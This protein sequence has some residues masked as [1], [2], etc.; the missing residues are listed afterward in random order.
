LPQDTS[1]NGDEICYITNYGELS[2]TTKPEI[3][4]LPT[5][6]K[7]AEAIQA[8]WTYLT[9]N[10]FCEAYPAFKVG[11]VRGLIFNEHSNGLAKSG[12]IVRQG[13]KVLIKPSAWFN[14]LE[15]GQTNQTGGK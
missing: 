8:A 13:R 12:A 7:Q 4:A 3:K 9:V 5:T 1:N 6:N 2:M 14:W 10:Q 11:G 15:S